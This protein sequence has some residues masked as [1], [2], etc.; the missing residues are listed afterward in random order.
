MLVLSRKSGESIKIGHDI[1]ITVLDIGKKRV[2]IGFEA[3]DEVP[4]MRSELTDW[5]AAPTSPPA[6]EEVELAYSGELA[7]TI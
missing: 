3:P 7:F 6:Y 1:T 5:S 4:I 2:R